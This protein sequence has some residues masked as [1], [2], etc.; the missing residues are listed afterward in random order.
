MGQ[1][2]FPWN[3]GSAAP[4]SVPSTLSNQRQWV[5][6]GNGILFSAFS[7]A[8]LTDSIVI[9]TLPAS[10]I[11]SGVKIEHT[12]AF[13]GPAITGATISVGNASNAVEYA[14]AFNV[15]QAVGPYQ[16]TSDLGGESLS[17]GTSIYATL[18]VVGADTNVLTAGVVD[19]WAELSIA[20]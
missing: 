2:A 18:T 1:S 15:F 12:T 6:V 9:F 20:R 16:L 4:S 7:A 13:S 11:I 5:L 14:G 3:R 8:A 10:A 17:A 19:I